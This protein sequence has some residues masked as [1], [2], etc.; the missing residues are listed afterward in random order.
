MSEALPISTKTILLGYLELCKPKVVVLIVF[1]AI[2]VFGCHNENSQ[3]ITSNGR[4]KYRIIVSSNADDFDLNAASELQR[5]IERISGVLIPV[6]DDSK[7]EDD[8]E[9]IVGKSGR[10]DDAGLRIDFKELG[11][12]GFV[13]K[14]VGKKLVI[15]GGKEKGTLYGVYTFLEDYLGCRNYSEK[16]TVIPEN[17]NITIGKID[18]KQ[19]PCFTF[20]EMHF[21]GPR[22]SEL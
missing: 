19:I 3:E 10:I 8:Y 22:H 7:P 11:D 20:R 15:A 5:Y 1:T 13:I 2:V 17:E 16:V 6:E 9:I 18:D 12:D 4:S 21:Y 14:T